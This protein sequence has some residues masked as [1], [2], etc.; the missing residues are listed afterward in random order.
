MKDAVA[1]V[2]NDLV[3]AGRI[4][5]G[6]GILDSFGHISVRHPERRDS[7]FISIARAAE[8]V[9]A[10]DIVELGMDGE[11]RSPEPRRLFAERILHAAVFVERPDVSAVCHHHAP[12][13]LP[14]CVT[15]RP[16]VP[17]LHLGAT[18]GATVPI[19]DSRDEFG[20]TNF[21]ISTPEQGRSMARALGPHWTVLLRNHG[22]TVAG[23]SL[24]ECVFRTI[25]GALN[26]AMLLQSSQLGTPRALTPGE[27]ELAGEFNLTPI[28]VDRS[29]DRWCHRAA[30]RIS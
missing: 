13:V 2:V 25:Y 11:P 7:F 18:M 29:W 20:D 4:L 28:A 23:R 24:R 17:V 6:E 19:W 12:A 9:T 10:E 30:S 22:A 14:F 26:A 1:A 15:G 21:L 8:L 3:I 27:A 16:L 5:A